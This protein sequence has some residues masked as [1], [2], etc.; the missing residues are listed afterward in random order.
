MFENNVFSFE[1][2]KYIQLNGHYWSKAG[3]VH[4]YK[5]EIDK[6]KL[7]TSRMQ[8]TNEYEIINVTIGE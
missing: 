5:M 6:E 2:D 3:N 8:R 4:K 7:K 1:L